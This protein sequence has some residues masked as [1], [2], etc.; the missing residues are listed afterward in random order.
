MFFNEVKILHGCI[1]CYEII[2]ASTA[3]YAIEQMNVTLQIVIL[4]GKRGNS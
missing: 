4:F 1:S 2:I 3:I